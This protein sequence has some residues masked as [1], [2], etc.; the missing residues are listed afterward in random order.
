MNLYIQSLR[1]FA[2]LSVVLYHVFPSYFANGFLGVDIFFVISGYL[3]TKSLKKYD[4]ISYFKARFLRIYPVLLI[5]ISLFLIL[6]SIKF[7]Y[8]ETIS[9]VEQSVFGLLGV[10]N[11]SYFLSNNY[12][13]VFDF[14]PLLNLW[15]LS[16]EIQFYLIFP[17]LYLIIKQNFKISII[18]FFISFVFSILAISVLP[19]ASF[20]LLPF[21]FWEFM[22]GSFAI[23]IIS[24][25]YFRYAF[26]YKHSKTVLLLMLSIVILFSQIDPFTHD[27]INGHPGLFS[28][29]ICL[30]SLAYILLAIYSNSNTQGF[31]FKIL[32]I[33]GDRSYIIY[34]VHYPLIYFFDFTDSKIVDYFL[35]FLFCLIISEFIYVMIDQRNYIKRS[36]A[37]FY[38]SL[39]IFISIFS[40]Y[41][42]IFIAQN[43][44]VVNNALAV[45]D[46][47]GY[48]CGLHY[49]FF[50]MKEEL[51]LINKA[52]NFQSVLLLGDS[53]ADA[54]KESF[55]DV[56]LNDDVNIYFAKDNAPFANK[57]NIEHLFREIYS[58]NISK[59]YILNSPRFYSNN[60]NYEALNYFLSM[61]KEID[62]FMIEP[63]PIYS[64]SIPEMILNN[65]FIKLADGAI[66]AK[67]M[68]TNS[69]V[70]FNSASYLNANII[71][72]RNSICS[73]DFCIIAKNNIPLYFDSEHLTLK[74]AELLGSYLK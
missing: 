62:V 29:I 70:D 25:Q 28:F 63:L 57:L 71:N 34:L 43:D 1:G 33:I 48:R 19:K 11:I 36:I 64:K 73:N 52:S 47:S 45:Y 61:A 50:P 15:S 3:I 20:Y 32:K 30:L 22:I 51:C 41:L 74:G 38:I 8:I 67:M 59:I 21:R 69:F 44:S 37:S 2:V 58:K 9:Y 12:F 53:H 7:N 27:F 13:S 4:L 56:F 18:F 39:T 42:T 60:V 23:Y 66:G 65:N 26:V 55:S 10:S 6:F 35:Y 49:R 5:V 16:L 14:K 24:R 40:T 54:I 31:I 46:R 72:I 17:F 68:M